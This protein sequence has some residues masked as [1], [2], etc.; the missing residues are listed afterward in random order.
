MSEVTA[1]TSTS[2]GSDDEQPLPGKKRKTKSES[3]HDEQFNKLLKIAQQEDH[4]VELVLGGLAKQI[5]R[6]LD[7]DEQ[8]ELLDE[9]QVVSSRHFREKRKHLRAAKNTS[10]GTTVNADLP[11]PPPLTAA[12]QLQHQNSLQAAQVN[13]VAAG[14]M[15][16]EVSDM[17]PLQQY[18][19]EYVRSE[20]GVTYMKI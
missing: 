15:L 14:E 16:F 10:A 9:I 18:S 3:A 13:E 2:T 11:P 12:G 1:S 17:P 20:E 6:T 5:I 19:V 7:H 8:D 4:P